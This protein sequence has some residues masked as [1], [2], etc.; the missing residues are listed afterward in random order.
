MRH[1]PE[2]TSRVIDVSTL[3]LLNGPPASEESTITERLAAPRPVTK[4]AI[5]ASG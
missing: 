1:L 3:V 4:A 2:G 5:D